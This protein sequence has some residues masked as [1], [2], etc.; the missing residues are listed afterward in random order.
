MPQL[1]I[2]QVKSHF[3]ATIARVTAG[4]TVI[5]CNR[6]KPVAEIRPL[7]QQKKLKKRPIGLA[8]KEYPEWDI[9]K[10]F[11][12]PLPDDILSCFTGADE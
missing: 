12:D 11:F 9:G 10:D 6:N 3:S 8:G 5:I 7:Q 2:S 1:N 4:E